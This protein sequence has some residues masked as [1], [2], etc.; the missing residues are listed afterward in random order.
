MAWWLLCVSAP[1]RAPSSSKP[2]RSSS[3]SACGF[4]AAE[5]HA[6][7]L[8]SWR[9][10]RTW[11][12]F[13]R[14][15]R[16]D[17]AV[18]RSAQRCSSCES[19][20]WSSCVWSSCALAAACRLSTR[21]AVP[22]A[23]ASAV[24]TR[25]RPR[26]SSSTLLRSASC[27]AAFCPRSPSSRRCSAP[28]ASSRRCTSVSVADTESSSRFWLIST[29]AISR[30]ISACALSSVTRST[31][32]VRRRVTMSFTRANCSASSVR[33]TC[34]STMPFRLLSVPLTTSWMRTCS[35]GSP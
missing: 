15:S 14:S 4:R 8:S 7:P 26:P 1:S 32:S 34:V 28:A 2:C 10:A 24:S 6:S 13:V 20:P 18:K 12:S 33:V 9:F 16:A 17:F 22:A 3:R 25:C 21:P 31:S 11:T 35:S 23:S 5:S 19:L 30:R 29:L 27:S